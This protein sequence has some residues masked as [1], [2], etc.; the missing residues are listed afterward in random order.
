MTLL[1]DFDNHYAHTQGVP[2][3]FTYTFIVTQQTH[4]WYAHLEMKYAKI[5][6]ALG[7][8]LAPDLLL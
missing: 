2:G 1:I 5:A 6:D 4:S 3:V 8:N 7:S